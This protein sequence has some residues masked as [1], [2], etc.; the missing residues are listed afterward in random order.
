LLSGDVAVEGRSRCDERDDR[1]DGGEEN[2]G[3]KGKGRLFVAE[4]GADQGGNAQPA[5]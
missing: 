4:I 5:G 1:L 2:G 3:G